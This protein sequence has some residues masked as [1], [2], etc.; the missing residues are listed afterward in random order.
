MYPLI[1]SF[2]LHEIG[3]L[4]HHSGFRVLEV[5][6]HMAHRGTYFGNDSRSMLLLTEKRG[7]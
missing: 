1:Q 4:L 5:S 7:Q 2:S 6:G 3:K